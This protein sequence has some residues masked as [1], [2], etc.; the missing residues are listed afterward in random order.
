MIVVAHIPP[1]K[2]I[3]FAIKP[4]APEPA[5]PEGVRALREL[6]EHIR[7]ERLWR[8]IVQASQGQGSKGN[9]YTAEIP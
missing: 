1:L 4:R 7:Y 5:E 6:G 8:L 2:R 9:E 3:D